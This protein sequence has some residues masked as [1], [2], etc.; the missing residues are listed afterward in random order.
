MDY[1]ISLCSI[2]ALL[3]LLTPPIQSAPTRVMASPTRPTR[4]EAVKYVVLVVGREREVDLLH[5]PRRV[6]VEVDREE[7]E[8]ARGSVAVVV[9]VGLPPSVHVVAR[10]HS[11]LLH[12]PLLSTL[13]RLEPLLA[14]VRERE[15]KKSIWLLLLLLLLLL[16]DVFSSSSS[17]SSPPLHLVGPSR[18]RRRRRPRPVQQG[19]SKAI[20]RPPASA[21]GRRKERGRGKRE[22]PARTARTRGASRGQNW[23]DLAL[24]IM[25]HF[26]DVFALASSCCHNLGCLIG[27]IKTSKSQNSQS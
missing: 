18:R 8:A 23:P 12:S 22:N 27:S 5:H 14:A 17:F 21:E 10:C 6:G 9:R 3:R 24:F 13:S 2:S 4:R 11:I 26:F 16:V 1:I 25:H 15:R 19:R 20:R 7:A